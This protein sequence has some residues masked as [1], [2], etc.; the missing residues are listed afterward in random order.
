MSVIHVITRGHV[1]AHGLF[2]YLKP[3]RCLWAVLSPGAMLL[4]VAHVAVRGHADVC[5][6]CFYRA[7]VKAY[8]DVCGQCCCWEPC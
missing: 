5:G 2:C 7:M 8:I 4:C 6:L 3:C 1:N